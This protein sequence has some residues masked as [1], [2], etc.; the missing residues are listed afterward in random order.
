MST[1]LTGEALQ[2]VDVSPGPHHH[3]EGR[4][5]FVAGRA[6]AGGAEQPEGQREIFSKDHSASLNPGQQETNLR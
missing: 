4:D 1:L 2:M 6:V 5:D 3:L